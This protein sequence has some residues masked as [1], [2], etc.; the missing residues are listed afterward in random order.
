[1][2]SFYQF[3]ISLFLVGLVGCVDNYQVT[4][5][6]TKG[7]LLVDGTITDL[8]EPQNITIS[9]TAE[10]ATYASSQFTS[11]VKSEQQIET[12]ITKANVKLIVNGTET[13]QF[14]ETEDGSYQL[15][16]NF[17]GKVGNSYQLVFQID[18][19]SYESTSEKMEAAVPIK[20][21]VEVFNPK[22]IKGV[23][24]GR[25]S[26]ATNDIFA[27]FED[28]PN[29]R[30]F[31][32]WRWVDWEIQNICETCQQSLYYLFQNDKGEI[33]GNCVKDATLDFNHVYDYQ[34]DGLCWDIFKS[35]GINIF[36]DNIG[37]GQTQ[38]GKLVA[39]IPLFQ[40][41]PCLLSIQQMSLTANAYRYFKLIQDQSV[42]TGTLV[43]TP[44]APIK[45][46]LT[47]LNDKGEL[48]LGFFS[49]SSV[50]EVRQ[51][52]SRKNTN[53]G[54]SNGLFITINNRTP[55]FEFASLERFFVPFAVIKNSKT[56]TSV[57]PYGWQ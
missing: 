40:A 15:P 36:A 18:G 22:G 24:K 19:N 17:K 23:F 35:S 10:N 53:G 31:Y 49:V 56:R 28:T 43:D 20:K 45:S 57:K 21:M 14:A 50:Y 34:C 12:P 54:I 2:K 1:M 47:N 26:I 25:E 9:R 42:E 48:V 11:T 13:W 41:N 4:I 16:L 32:R 37:D 52:L 33:Y 27:D 29:V 8:D 30:N 6:T 46:N 39:Q 44:P 51:M 3:F 7:Y 55:N 5:Q 38:K